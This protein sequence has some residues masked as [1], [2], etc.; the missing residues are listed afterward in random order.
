MMQ[1]NLQLS[2]LSFLRFTTVFMCPF[3]PEAPEVE[4]SSCSLRT[5]AHVGHT[6]L[7]SSPS[8]LPEQLMAH[9]HL[10]VVVPGSCSDELMT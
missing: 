7:N 2:L 8:D 4:K 6:F 1:Y 5:S 10:G 9:E 3:G